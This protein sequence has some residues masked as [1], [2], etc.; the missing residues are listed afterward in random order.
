MTPF[1]YSLGVD[2]TLDEARQMMAEHTIHHLPVTDDGQL[3]GIV[4]LRDLAVAGA[5]S[6]DAEMSLDVVYRTEPL[7]VDIKTPLDDVVVAMFER[8]VDSALVTRNAKLVGILTYSDVAKLL[9]T[10]LRE[11]FPVAGDDQPA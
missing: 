6:V 7:V 4:S 2:A 5:M 1:P 11:V 9:A 3:V 10:I 8:R